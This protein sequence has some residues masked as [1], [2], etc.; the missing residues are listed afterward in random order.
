MSALLAALLLAFAHLLHP[1]VPPST[2]QLLGVSEQQ[3]QAQRALNYPSSNQ[4]ADHG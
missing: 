2:D 1:P 4:E 3:G